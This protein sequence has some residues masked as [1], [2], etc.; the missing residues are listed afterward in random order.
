LSAADSFK[1]RCASCRARNR[2]PADKVGQQAK[3][4]KCGAAIETQVLA[5]ARPVMVSDANFEEM[6]LKSPLPT[7]LYCWA[8]WCP[9]CKQ[10]TPVVDSFAGDARG[11]VRVAKLNVD[12][13][14]MTAAKYDVR[15]VPFMF[16][17][18]NGQIRENM[19]AVASK[20]DLMMV[21]GR[22][23]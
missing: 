18:D 2:I 13:N 12:T 7:L 15:S 23:I 8:T 5:N 1:L 3:C 21:M 4:G 17:F 11:R 20:H 9:G 10:T 22:Y 16:V 6:V 14:P 19:P